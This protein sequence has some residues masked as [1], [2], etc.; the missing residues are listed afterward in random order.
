[1]KECPSCKAKNKN[2]AAFCVACG[3]DLKDVPATADEWAAAAGDFLN[4]AKEAATVGAKKAKEAAAVGAQKAREA[5][6]AGTEK[7]KKAMDEADKKV[8]AAKASGVTSGG[9]DTAVD[10]QANAGGTPKGTATIL[11][12]QSESV[13]AT[14]GNNYLQ[15]FLMGGKVKRGIGILTQKRFYYKGK[16]YSGGGKDMKS[17]TQEG[18]VSV[19]D[20][21]FTQFTYTRP[22]GWLITAIMFT[23]VGLLFLWQSQVYPHSSLSYFLHEFG[24]QMGLG[25]FVVALFFFI[26][27]FLNR[28][29]VFVISFPGGGF[30]FDI[31]YYPIADIRDFQRQLHLLKDHRKEG[32]DA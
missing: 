17:A 31:K 21:A 1:M 5:T 22:T 29:S 3:A 14:I 25:A 23:V 19:D 13:V 20:I 27:Y 2:D 7:V 8:T 11:V 18:V 28:H 16:S 6:A 10:F 24:L 4:K 9:W 30:G 32:G 15:N 12:D 26:K